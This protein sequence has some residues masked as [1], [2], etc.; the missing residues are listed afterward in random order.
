[1]K[2]HYSK[3][4]LF[5][6]PLNILVSS[7]YANNKN[8]AYIKSHTAS[9]TSRVL[10]EYDLYESNYDNDPFMKSVKENFHRQTSQRFEE[11]DERMITQR[12]KFKEQRDKDIQKIIL[13]DK[14]DK[15]LAEKVE[16]VCLMC[17][18][19]LGGVAASV[20]IIGAIAVNEFKK[21]A[22]LAATQDAIAEGAVA[23]KAAG[24]IMGVSE[25]IKGINTEFGASTL[26]GKELG[27]IFNASNYTNETF[28]SGYIEAEY[29]LLSCE[30]LNAGTGA[31][32]SFC[33]LV[34]QKTLVEGHTSGEISTLEGITKSVTQLVTKAKG[35]AALKT[36]EVTTTQTT[37]LEA[38]KKSAIET[39]CMGY[40]TTIIASIV[41]ILIIAVLMFMI[42]LI[43][44]Y[45]RKKKM[46]K[47]AEYTKLL[48]Q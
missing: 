7:S 26:V 1:M 10:I 21:A 41:A 9:T 15:S 5:S 4:L 20:G 16:K 46:N 2:L 30:S 17:G 6:L 27:S 48:N 28:I 35:A 24:D 33:S 22:L 23:G 11:Y 19:G 42:Y 8:K 34:M 12:Q 45:R 43:L 44:R 39:T 29:K 13:K 40:Q 31:H 36:S 32:Q 18:C 25:L 37:I 47:K 3:I 14:M 38:A